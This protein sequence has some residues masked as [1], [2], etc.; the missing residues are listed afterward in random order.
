MEYH[1]VFQVGLVFPTYLSTMPGWIESWWSAPAPEAW[2]ITRADSFYRVNPTATLL[3]MFTSW[4]HDVI[5]GLITFAALTFL[6]IFAF[7]LFHATKWIIAGLWEVVLWVIS[8]EQDTAGSPQHFDNDLPDGSKPVTMFPA[9]TNPQ[10]ITPEGSIAS[11]SPIA[12]LAN[13]TPPPSIEAP[14]APA[15][16]WQ[17]TTTGAIVRRTSR[18]TRRLRSN[19]MPRRP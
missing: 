4:R 2:D 1:Q 10:V 18:F 6:L 5:L 13:I 19:S 16:E 8:Q 17:E 15:L 9:L 12:Q 7:V 11:V 3:W 14:H